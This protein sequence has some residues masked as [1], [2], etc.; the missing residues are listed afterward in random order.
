MHL[1]SVSLLCSQLPPSSSAFSILSS[2]HPLGPFVP[3]FLTVAWSGTPGWTLSWWTGIEKV[4]WKMYRPQRF[5]G[6]QLDGDHGGEWRRECLNQIYSLHEAGGW[7][8]VQ[9]LGLVGGGSRC[10]SP[11]RL[12]LGLLLLTPRHRVPLSV[13]QGSECSGWQ[14]F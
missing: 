2:Q 4:S 7:L 8:A 12:M 13:Y 10:F 9:G 1:T 11:G 3:C 6:M 14:K 5:S